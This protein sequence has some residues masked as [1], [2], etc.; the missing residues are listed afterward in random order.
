MPAER[1]VWVPTVVAAAARF[2]R[3]IRRPP[4][5]G[6]PTGQGA[7]PAGRWL[8]AR[9]R[10]RQPEPWEDAVVEP[11]HGADP[12]AGKGEHVEAHPVAD[13]VRGAQVG[14]ERR[15]AVGSRWHEVEPAARAEQAGAEAGH[16]VS[17]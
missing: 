17:A 9:E 14:S 5:R 8:S 4:I 15:L 7:V 6:S 10:S 3:G 13:A 16:D 12:V 11:G 2:R 1:V